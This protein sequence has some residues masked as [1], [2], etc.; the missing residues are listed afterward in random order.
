M[1]IAKG[2]PALG[3]LCQSPKIRTKWDLAQTWQFWHHT[4]LNVPRKWD[5][6]PSCHIFAH[7]LCA[8]IID[9]RICVYLNVYPH[10]SRRHISTLSAQP[11]LLPLLLQLHEWWCSENKT[12]QLSRHLVINIV[13]KFVPSSSF[14]T[15]I[16]IVNIL[17]IIG[18]PPHIVTII[19]NNN[20]DPHHLLILNPSK[21]WWSAQCCHKEARVEKEEKQ[22]GTASRW[23]SEPTQPPSSGDQNLRGRK[24]SLS[25]TSQ[26][27]CWYVASH[28][29]DEND[30]KC[31]NGFVTQW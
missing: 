16:S 24:C 21:L 18:P 30:G 20:H 22:V 1:A 19:P 2:L 10:Q 8:F 29:M 7:F 25:M 3:R 13:P 12:K 11:P 27:H 31:G 28:A 23:L 17:V 4:F 5:P 26:S 15:G 6:K 9:I 14:F